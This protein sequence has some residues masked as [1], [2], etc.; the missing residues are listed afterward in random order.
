M[1][2]ETL[3][4]RIKQVRATLS[5]ADFGARLGVTKDTIGKYERG[6]R[7]PDVDFLIKICSEF[8]R[9]ADWLLTGWEPPK[10]WDSE[11]YDQKLL[12][13]PHELAETFDEVLMEQIGRG[14]S[15]AY[16]EENARIETGQLMRLA[17][18][19][20]VDL[21]AFPADERPVALKGILTQLRREIRSQPLDG[22]GKRSA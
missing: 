17:T 16:R 6:E 14:I 10:G 12:A 1:N 15:S 21:M 7:Q 18:R 3:G 4:S 11:E 20:Y 2:S 13:H 22:Q 19:Y 8:N 9:S 5:Q